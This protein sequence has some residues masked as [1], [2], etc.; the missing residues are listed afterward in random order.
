[1]LQAYKYRLYPNVKQQDDIEKHI[2]CCRFVYNTFLA[3]KI[4][5]Y[6][7]F[8]DTN[9]KK[10]ISCYE[11]N[12]LLPGLKIEFPFLQEVNSQ[13]LQMASKNLDSAYTR[14]FREL[15]KSSKKK[16]KVG[17]PRFKSKKNPVQSFQCPQFVRV[18][19]ADGLVVLPKIGSIKCKFH[20]IF[21]GQIKTCTVSKTFSTGKYYVSILVDDGTPMP[22]KQSF[23]VDSTIGID[24][25]LTHFLVLSNGEK[26]DNP[27]N[28]VMASRKLRSSQKSVSRKVKGSS[29]RKKSIKKLAICHEKVANRRSDFLHKLSSKVVSENQAIAIEDLNVSGMI[30]NYRLAK[31]IADASWSEFKTMLTYKSKKYGKT[32]LIIGR[33]EPSSKICSVCGYRNDTLTLADREWVCPNC[34]TKHDRDVNAAINIK[35]IALFNAKKTG[36]EPSEEPVEIESDLSSY[37]G[38]LR[39][40]KQEA[41]CESVG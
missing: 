13:S 31:S 30:K 7:E 20:R 40:V 11:L 3:K 22:E 18:N 5:H 25:G 41:P 24:L 26:V 14:F 33:F 8:K 32:L 23:S 15:K 1:M 6:K 37:L 9:E 35:Q 36:W 10:S 27:R 34:G 16:R 12:N 4:A 29:N 2:G 17:F 21:D 19:F 28:L 38:K 39:S